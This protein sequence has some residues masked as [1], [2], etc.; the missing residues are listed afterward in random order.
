MEHS[1]TAYPTLKDPMSGGLG[2]F[3]LPTWEG[4][5]TFLRLAPQH[6]ISR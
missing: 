5:G 3:N 2:A 4:Q 1:M 6:L